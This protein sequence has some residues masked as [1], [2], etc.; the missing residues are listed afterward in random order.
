MR[1]RGAR[2]GRAGQ[3]S[4]ATAGCHGPSRGRSD[5]R[6]GERSVSLASASRRSWKRKRLRKGG[7]RPGPQTIEKGPAQP[8][9][10]PPCSSQGTGHVAGSPHWD[11][12][13]PGWAVRG[14]RRP[15]PPRLQ[16]AAGRA[17]QNGGRRQPQ[18]RALHTGGGR[19]GR[20]EIGGQNPGRR[21]GRGTHRTPANW[22]EG[23]VAKGE[24]RG[25]PHPPGKGHHS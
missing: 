22:E 18:P 24:E 20:G 21:P 11:S 3:R 23:V 10:R 12:G 5:P 9:A 1:S 8:G 4:P 14:S 15:G 2:L 13:E 19:P 7:G 16:S 6:S 17:R 25:R